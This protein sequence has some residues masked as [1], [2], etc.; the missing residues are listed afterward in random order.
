MEKKEKIK[1]VRITEQIYNTVK[2]CLK[3]G[4]STRTI[5]ETLGI[6]N[7]SVC[8]IRKYN[9]Y[10]EYLDF[11]RGNGSTR[12]AEPKPEDKPEEKPEE[13]PNQITIDDLPLPVTNEEY[14]RLEAIRDAVLKQTEVLELLSSKVSF[15]I[16]SLTK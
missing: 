12:Y 8:R 2:L 13:V 5:A 16:D 15:L 6:S 9:T 11:V 1:R 3:G 14:Q 10:E 7:N 4:T